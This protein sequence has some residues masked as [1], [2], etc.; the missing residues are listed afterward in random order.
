MKSQVTTYKYDGIFNGLLPDFDTRALELF[1][2]QYQENSLYR[3]FGKQLRKSPESVRELNQIP[4]L[5]VSFFKTKE[6][7]TGDFVPE[8]IFESSGTTGTDTA[9][10]FIKQSDLYRESFVNGFERFYG[11]IRDYCIL[12]LLPGYLERTG[13][14]LIWMVNEMIRI[15]GHEE[16]GFYLYDFEKL[17]EVLQKL[18]KNKQRTVLIGVSFALLDF[19]EKYSMNL[20]NTIVMETGGM[21]GRRE[22]ITRFELH[23]FLKQKLGVVHVHSEYGM[24]E[25]LSQAYS[26]GG[27]KYKSVPWMK[28]LVR[29]E[30]DPLSVH[31][32]GEG[33]LNI[34]DLANL[35]SC[36]FIATDDVIRLSEDGSFEVLGRMD[37]S[38]VRGCS[39]LVV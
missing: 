26:S 23:N 22:E 11:E 1:K 15:S 39:L 33:L 16:S 5:P 18:E 9:K 24:T 35:D 30:D 29:D 38:D 13:S 7:K 32:T 25:L 2:H 8:I 34:I 3:N 19:A 6:V 17:Y 37:N 28:V 20:S 21:K 14:S 27:G 36:A 4:F 10:H 12:G 31:Q